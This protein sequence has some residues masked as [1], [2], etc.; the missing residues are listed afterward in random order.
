MLVPHLNDGIVFRS[1]GP[2]D[3]SIH[4]SRQT[5]DRFFGPRRNHLRYS[6]PQRVD[7]ACSSRDI[8]STCVVFNDS[9][10][11]LEVAVVPFWCS[12]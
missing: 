1:S 6:W 12:I 5:T 10:I 2:K 8:M 11:M 3:K 4:F 9:R 7:T